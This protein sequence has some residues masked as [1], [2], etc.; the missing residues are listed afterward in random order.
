MYD[1]ALEWHFNH[2]RYVFGWPSTDSSKSTQP[3]WVYYTPRTSGLLRQDV[4]RHNGMEEHLE[5]EWLADYTTMTEYCEELKILGSIC[6]D[7]VEH[8]PEAREMGIV[9]R[10][11]KVEDA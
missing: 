8:S 3:V 4:L 10:A 11:K 1:N 2:C 9:E 6:Y 7:D 5:L